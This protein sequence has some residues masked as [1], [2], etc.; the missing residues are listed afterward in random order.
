MNWTLYSALTSNGDIVATNTKINQIKLLEEI[1]K[2]DN[3]WKD[4]NPKTPQMKRKALAVT[5]LDGSLENKGSIL[6][7]EY[8]EHDFNKPTEV[9]KSSETL[10]KLLSP[11]IEYLG[12]TQIL[13]LEEGGFFPSHIDEGWRLPPESFRLVV[14]LADCN[15]PYMW[16]MHGDDK[17]YK[18]LTWQYGTLYFVNTL[19]KHALFNTGSKDSYFLIANVRICE[20]SIT[21]LKKKIYT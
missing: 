20:E 12:R 5:S 8:S 17:E 15:P 9:Y 13:K 2:F 1:E 6:S 16:W 4:Y 3:A 7:S 10:Q 18:S 21:L 14:A 11:W 19:K